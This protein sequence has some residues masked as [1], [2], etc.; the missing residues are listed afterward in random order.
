MWQELVSFVGIGFAA[1]MIDG[2]VGMAYGVLASSSLLGLGVA[3]AA[4]ARR[5]EVRS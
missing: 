1:Q 4:Q 2:A 5:G 3:R